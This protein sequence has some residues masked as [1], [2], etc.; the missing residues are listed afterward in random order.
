MVN[1]FTNNI[2]TEITKESL[3]VLVYN[4]H[5]NNIFSES[6]LKDVHVLYQGLPIYVYLLFYWQV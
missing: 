4:S 5:E 6:L 2:F 3:P 1:L